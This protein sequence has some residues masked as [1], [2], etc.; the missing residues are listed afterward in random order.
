MP[1]FP[2][3]K[4]SE[5]PKQV[6]DAPK[7]NGAKD[8]TAAAAKKPKRTPV[9]FKKAESKGPVTR[10]RVK[11][12]S[13]SK[14]SK[15]KSPFKDLG[16]LED[17]ESLI[18]F[19]DDF[20]KPVAFTILAAGIVAL[21]FW[22]ST[23]GENSSNSIDKINPIFAEADALESETASA[24]TPRLELYK[25]K[26][27]VAERLLEFSD[28]PSAQERGAA[29]KLKTLTQWLADEI[30]TGTDNPEITG[31][32]EN[33]AREFINSRNKDVASYSKIGLTLIRARNYL[34]NPN[35][36]FFPEILDQFT[37]VSSF[38]ASD[39]PSAQ[40]LMKLAQTFQKEGLSEEASKLYRAINLKCSTSENQDIANIGMQAR[41]Q[42][43]SSTAVLEDLMSLIKPKQKV[44]LTPLKKK[45]NQ[46]IN[47][48]SVS[49][50]NLESVL[51]FIEFLNRRNSILASKGLL[52]QLENSIYL[53][54]SGFER[55][56]IKQR[57]DSIKKRVD[58]FGQTFSFDGLY[59]VEGRPI[60]RASLQHKQKL[61]V[62]WSPKN[63]KSVELLEKI[64]TKQV[65]F[66]S[67][68][69]QVVA[70]ANIDEAG[71]S[72]PIL[73][74]SNSTKG[75]EFLTVINGDA[76]SRAF[77][78]RFPIPQRPYWVIL[79]DNDRIRGLHA[80]IELLK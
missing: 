29:L 77:K 46:Y 62:F 36:K 48:E 19:R 30:N 42:L 27:D 4:N 28:E 73:K 31:S 14:T 17:T 41:S 64:S 60:S 18:Q 12:K 43:N 7:S 80:P 59:S 63:S 45:I 2:Y 3:E 78:S 35:I 6:Q 72:E 34:A 67:L 13:R 69:V 22:M 44:E 10:V 76:R 1:Q 38:A 68:G 70:I 75:I 25:K 79:D 61:I 40:N 47:A 65:R 56:A 71:A 21:I 57:F 53:L 66:E 15:T 23:T 54:D 11:G 58:Q 16:V 8:Q 24:N 20:G 37:L 39:L 32:L 50:G 26:L 49:A 51:D 9:Q 52:D 55:D 5:E 74:M 33:S